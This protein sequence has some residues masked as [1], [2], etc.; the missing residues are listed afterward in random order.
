[1]KLDWHDLLAASHARLG[2]DLDGSIAP[3]SSICAPAL[4][5]FLRRRRH[6]LIGIY[7]RPAGAE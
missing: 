4:P 1:V 7:E 3:T 6:G 2:L 5:V